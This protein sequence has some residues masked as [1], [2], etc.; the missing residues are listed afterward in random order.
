MTTIIAFV[1][2][3]VLHPTLA[4]RYAKLAYQDGLDDGDLRQIASLATWG[5][6][7]QNVSR[8]LHRFLPCAYGSG[9]A[10]HN[11]VIN[12][13]DNKTSSIQQRELPIL[14]ASDTLHAIWTTKSNAAWTECLG[15]T[16]D[17]CKS[18]WDDAGQTWARDHPVVQQGLQ[19]LTVPA[20]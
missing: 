7:P 20:P 9:L 8:D 16:Y 3:E 5:K 19:S 18:Y 4:Q 11:I 1:A 15:G 17:L 13:W 6:H 2:R 10:T 14:L 12:A